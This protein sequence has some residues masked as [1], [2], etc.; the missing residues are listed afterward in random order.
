MVFNILPIIIIAV[1]LTV[2]AVIIV[3][4][5]PELRAL[6]VDSIPEERQAKVKE[7]IIDERVNRA[8]QKVSSKLGGLF[9]PSLTKMK[10]KFKALFQKVSELEKKYEKKEQVFTEEDKKSVTDRVKESLA[11]AEKMKDSEQYR[12]AEKKYIEIISLD[13]KNFK[14]YEGLARIYVLNKDFDMAKETYVHLIRTVAKE[15]NFPKNQMASYYFELAEVFKNKDNLDKCFELM[16]K[17]VNM[18]PNSP[19]YLDFYIDCS[20]NLKQKF[21]A[22]KA[23]KRLKQI[24]P[25]N[26][27]IVEF[28]RRINE[29]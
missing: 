25:D 12:E 18:D 22:L 11:E 15:M 8:S 6:D 13:P 14:A 7:K 16:Q 1:C 28:E 5:F 26:Q 9:F 19:K 20:I 17:V 27:K 4:K 2:I 23:M 21:E 24:N 10:N 3:R 29:I